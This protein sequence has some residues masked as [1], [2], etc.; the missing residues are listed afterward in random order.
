MDPEAGA[1]ACPTPRQPT[2]NTTAPPCFPVFAVVKRLLTMDCPA[3]FQRSTTTRDENRKSTSLTSL[4]TKTK[5]KITV[6][7]WITL[8]RTPSQRGES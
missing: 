2:E 6:T 7:H 4:D 3:G 1:A 8:I 5:I